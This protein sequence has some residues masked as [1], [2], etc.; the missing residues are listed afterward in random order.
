M[1]LV[2]AAPVAVI[3]AL[4]ALA[5]L[6]AWKQFG[7]AITNALN[8]NLPVVGRVLGGL[9][10]DGL[11]LAYASTLYWFD[12]LL[13]PVVN[14]FL[15]PIAAIENP[16]MAI[17][18]A[19][20]QTANAIVQLV[21]VRLPENFVAGIDLTISEANSIIGTLSNTIYQNY[22]ALSDVVSQIGADVAEGLAKANTYTDEAIGRLEP[23]VTQAL[24]EGGSIADL[25][26]SVA[27]SVVAAATADIASEISTAY[28]D[29]TGYA[30]ALFRTAESDITTALNEATTYTTTAIA[31]IAG[32][33]ATDIE[34]GIAGA[35][36]G[37][38]TDVDAAITDVIGIA[39]TGDAD[40]IDAIRDIPTSIPLDIAGVA[41][42]AGATTLTLARYLRDCG[43]PNCQNLGQFGKDLQALLGLVADASFLSFLVELVEHPADAASTIDDTFGSIIGDTVSGFRDLVGV[44]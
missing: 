16:I 13:H 11:E 29:A 35:L 15:G 2:V 39:G 28:D 26:T 9:I 43:I 30:A 7:T 41:S 10:A 23:L 1:P 21:A 25:A 18:Y 37:I 8:V 27:Q 3:A 34:Q 14:F 33:T 22:G 36:S 38:Y 5:F 12:A 4:L 40:V 24:A 6:L 44:L 42:L 31:G 20:D 17:G 32:I 19:L